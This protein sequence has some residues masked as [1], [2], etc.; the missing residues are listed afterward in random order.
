M[1]S[2]TSGVRLRTRRVTSWQNG[3]IVLR[4][5][6]AA[7][8]ETEKSSRKIMGHQDLWMLKPVLGEETINRQQ[9]RGA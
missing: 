5:A 8:L 2:P 4:C 3:E 7:P 1:E 9:L 6:A